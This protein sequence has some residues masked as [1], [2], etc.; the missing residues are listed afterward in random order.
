MLQKCKEFFIGATA[1]VI[2]LVYLAV[3]IIIVL[4]VLAIGAYCA[5]AV[6][7]IGLEILRRL[8]S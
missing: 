8:L 4:A 5:I 2:A 3:Q 6:V 7:R 1:L